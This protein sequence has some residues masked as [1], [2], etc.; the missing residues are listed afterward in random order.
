MLIYPGQIDEV[1]VRQDGYWYQYIQS[2]L[3]WSA[4]TSVAANAGITTCDILKAADWSSETVFTKF[5][6][7]PL[8]S[9]LGLQTTTVDMWD[10][11]FWNT[12]QNGSAHTVGTRLYEK[13]EV[14]HIY[15]ILYHFV[16]YGHYKALYNGHEH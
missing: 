9:E 8:R 4:A 2:A 13:G 11:A 6:Y 5:Y 1:L 15:Y 14:D 12:L 16:N 3:S 10:W 7:K